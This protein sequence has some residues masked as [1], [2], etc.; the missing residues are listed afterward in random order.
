M[1]EQF[2]RGLKYVEKNPTKAI[3]I[4]KDFIKNTKDCKEAWLNLAVAYKYMGDYDKAIDAL[5]RANS[6][7]IPFSDN[8]FAKE[9]P[10]A[11][12]NLGLIANTLEDSAKA[13][14]FYMAALAVE[15]LNYD[16]LWNLS[17]CKLRNHASERQE[18]LNVA[19]KL[20]EFRLKR[21]GAK[22][23]HVDRA[24]HAWDYITK[25]SSIVVLSEQGMG[26]MIMFGRY[27]SKLKEFADKIWIQCHPSLKHIFKDYNTCENVSETDASHYVAMGSLGRMLDYIPPA[28][29]I[30]GGEVSESSKLR[31]LCVWSG[32][33]N[34]I[35][36]SKRS[37]SSFFFN[38]FSKY[39][40]LYSYE[41]VPGFKCLEMGSWEKTIEQLRDIDLVISV[42]TSIVHLCGSI[43]KPCWVLMPLVDTDFRWGESSMGFNNIWYPSVTVIRNPN[44]WV[45]TF[46][47]AEE[48][49]NAQS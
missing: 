13:E 48:L 18:D 43:G 17:I 25:V 44:S 11:L 5:M 24:C 4:F 26:D 31:I 30:D 6:P 16:V 28:Q 14:K 40:E 29:W 1:L 38:R 9:Y 10:L 41:K 22:P 47:L 35:N 34:H 23:L 15:P 12:N 49:F 21:T 36:D 32:N 7:D 8:T 39:G 37:C 20:Y 3:S 46:G 33:K 19:W 2:N 45:E 27:L 42:D